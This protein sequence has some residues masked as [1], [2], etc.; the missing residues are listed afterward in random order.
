ME[1][2]RR[3][4]LIDW[5]TMFSIPSAARPVNRCAQRII[6]RTSKTCECACFQ[7]TPMA[8]VTSVLVALIPDR[9]VGTLVFGKRTEL[10]VCAVYR[11]TLTT[12]TVRNIVLRRTSKV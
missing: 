12:H 6:Q 4:S 2:P 7:E 11:K 8:T 1:G 3:V 5:E 9:V 10:P